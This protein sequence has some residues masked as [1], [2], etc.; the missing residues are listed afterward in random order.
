MR[1]PTRVL[2][3]LL[4]ASGVWALP[5]VADVAGNSVASAPSEATWGGRL[6]ARDIALD[7]AGEPTGVWSDGEILWALPGAEGSGAHAYDLATGARQSERDLELGADVPAAALWS[8]GRTL[9]APAGTEARVRA[10]RLLDGKPRS[11]GDLHGAL[12]SAGNEAPAGVWSDGVVLYVVDSADAHVH[13]YY[14]DGTR[15]PKRE[16]SLLADDVA[17]GSPWGLWSDGETV[18]TSWSGEGTLRAY[19]LADG[20]RLPDRDIDV[21]ASGNTDPRDLWSDGETLWVVDGA[22]RKLYA[23][24]VPGLSSPTPPLPQAQGPGLG[25]LGYAETELF[26]PVSW[27]DRTNGV[28]ANRTGRLPYGTNI[29]VMVNG[30]FVTLFAPDSGR[31]SGGFLVY[32]VSNPRQLRRV[33]RVFDPRGTTAA[34]REAHSLGVA[35]IDGGTYIAIQARDG[36]EFWDFSDMDDIRRASRLPLPGISGGDY[37][38]V[39]Q[40]T[41]Q[42][43][44]VYAA[45]T[46]KGLFVID[47]NDPKVPFVARRPDGPNPVPPSELGGFRVGPVFAMGNQ[48]V[49]SGMDTWDGW[50]S[51]D[52][53]DPLNPVLMDKVADATFFYAL[54]FDGRR[55]YANGL[56]IYD[57]S[58]PASFVRV[59]ANKVRRREEY[60]AT[61]D[62]FVFQGGSLDFEKTD[63]SDVDNHRTI[64]K[65]KLLR[66]GQNGQV[67]PLGNLVFV[68]DDK[69]HGSG[70]V[71]HDRQPDTTP[72]TVLAVSPRDGAT[73]QAVTSRI[74]VA[75]SDSVLLESANPDTVRLLGE[76]GEAVEGAYS[77]Q[78][79]IVNFAPASRLEPGSRYTIDVP[80]GDVRDSAGNA[81][82]EAFQSTFETAELGDER[83]KALAPGT[84]EP[85]FVGQEVA[86]SVAESAEDGGMYTWK[87]GDGTVSEASTE[88]TATHTYDAPG[89]YTVVL[90]VAAGGTT[91][92]H[93]FVRR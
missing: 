16:F 14:R 91:R 63:V 93:S 24:A 49:L 2:P 79:G 58:D 70:F 36:V 28:P 37:T 66:T 74:G 57:L 32:D 77:V 56:T 35:R 26:Q 30:Y 1:L 89:H 69:G 53:S 39:W 90:E 25:N 22:D 12:M 52:I 29:G 27:I 38:G 67:T 65:G 82:A 62:S 6:A 68:G 51:L 86:F 9:W 88:R 64:G 42:A 8:D 43:P 46:G 45:V 41:W 17:D 55:V 10:F 21:G 59:S 34:F 18:L 5:A 47:A 61:Q 19:R 84:F 81:L 4:A 75:F 92:Y 72:P 48:L 33:A 85:G 60:C 13:A 7:G 80:A 76:D 44:Y 31:A 40:L 83:L 23:H 54:C 3:W 78:F 50:S 71:V 87:F 15:L 20:Q 11:S 73:G